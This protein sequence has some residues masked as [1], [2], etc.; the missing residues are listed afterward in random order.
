MTA[1]V[2]DCVWK[3]SKRVRISTQYIRLETNEID[4]EKIPSLVHVIISLL[5]TYRTID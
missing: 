2:Q 4:I 5:H 1:K 3:K